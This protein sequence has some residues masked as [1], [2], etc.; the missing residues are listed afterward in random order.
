VT[1]ESPF[2]WICTQ[3]WD[4]C[5]RWWFY[6]QFHEVPLYCV[7]YWLYHSTLPPA[8]IESSPFSTHASAQT[9]TLLFGGPGFELRAFLLCSTLSLCQYN[10]MF[11][12][13]YF[14]D[15]VLCFLPRLALNYNPPIF[16]QCNRNYRHVSQYFSYM[17]RWVFTK[18]FP[19]LVLNNSPLDPYLLSSWENRHEPPHL[20]SNMN[21]WCSPDLIFFFLPPCGNFAL[22]CPQAE[23]QKPSFIL[24]FLLDAQSLNL[25]TLPVQCIYSTLHWNHVA[26]K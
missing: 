26:P 23:S 5:I 1:Q 17:L 20:T 18:P 4:C 19:D 12:F 10:S 13:S 6:F 8:V 9:W 15:K 11:C 24:L 3:W 16:A 22:Q 2:L 14:S 25:K 21:S 7:L